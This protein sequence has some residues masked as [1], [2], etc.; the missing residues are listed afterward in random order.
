MF[1]ITNPVYNDLLTSKIL[2]K[3][4]KLQVISRFTR[5]K[6]IRVLQDPK[7]QIIFLEK[8]IT[9]QKH[10]SS[11]KRDEKKNNNHIDLI[12]GRK[13]K[14]FPLIND[15]LRRF[16]QF[17]KFL[18]NKTVLD[19]GCGFGKFIFLCKK[20]SKKIYG[21][22]IRELAS[23]YLK[24]KKIVVRP[25][26]E[27]FKFKFDV[28]TMFHVL[29]HL[30]NQIESLKMANSKLKKGGK[31]IIEVPHSKDYLFEFKNLL[32]FKMFTFYSEH[33]IL[34]TER[35]LITFLKRANFK[36]IKIIYFQRYNFFNHLKWF[37]EGKPGGHL[38]KN[39]VHKDK[40][41]IQHYNDY[42][43]RLK[44]TDTIIA[45]AEK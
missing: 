22:E 17:K 31:I 35:S 11:V 10:Y 14:R 40:K 12:I 20:Y 34:H 43:S 38:D 26:I 21:V 45:I 28:I 1:N 41:I 3:S 24:K 7:E 16:N 42:L 36:K 5:D 19:Y 39:Y 18:K 25:K 27:D 30:P 2:K 9:T 33:L 37:N 6:K 8:Y 32:K 13:L 44:K 23:K 29:E 4:N 15:E